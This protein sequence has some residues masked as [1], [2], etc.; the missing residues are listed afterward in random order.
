MFS[1]SDIHSTLPNK[2]LRANFLSFFESEFKNQESVIIGKSMLGEDIMCYKLGKGKRRIL[3]VA[4]HHAAEY[5]SASALYDFIIFLLDKSARGEVY[6]SVNLRLLLQKFT[7]WIIPCLNPDGVELNL[8]GPCNSPLALRQIRM[9]ENAEDFSLWQANARGVDLN[10]NYDFRFFEYK[11][12][13]EAKENIQAGKTK[14][15]GEYPESEPESRALADFTRA[16][17]PSLVV[18]LHTQGEE[19]YSMPKSASV[20][21][22]AGRA[23]RLIGYK[24]KEPEGTA[25]YGGFCDYTGAALGIP[26]LTVELGKGKNPL[27]FSFLGGIIYKTRL[28]LSAL[29]T[30][31]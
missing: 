30:L 25:A 15:S 6:G 23:A 31:L 19:I 20:S 21:R 12:E 13:I 29:P 3:Y 11:R 26:S 5:I 9:N 1:I 22:L 27:P 8:Y 4:A 24:H 7:F 16:L 10:H 18:S 14:Y 28:L 2:S 17:M